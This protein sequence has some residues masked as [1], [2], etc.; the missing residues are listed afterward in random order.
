[1]IEYNYRIIKQVGIFTMKIFKLTV[2]SFLL[3]MSLVLLIACG[4]KIED[5][6]KKLVG[7]W[8]G[9]YGT[10]ILY[11]NKEAYVDFRL[12]TDGSWEVKDGNVYIKRDGE[13][14]DLIAKIPNGEFSE[15]GFYIAKNGKKDPDYDGE[16]SMIFMKQ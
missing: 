1:M 13:A 10:I 3:I 2:T 4:N 9:K 5:Q 14:R 6:E 11:D 12:E 7:K 15:L 16:S 8:E